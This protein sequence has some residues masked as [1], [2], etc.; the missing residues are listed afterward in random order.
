ME[1]AAAGR[2]KRV[3]N[4]GGRN[5][6][7]MRPPCPAYFFFLGPLGLEVAF[8]SNP[9]RKWVVSNF[10]KKTNNPNP[11]PIG[12]RFGLYGR[13]AGGGTRTPTMSP[14]ADFESATSTNSITPANT[15]SIIHDTPRFRKRKFYFSGKNLNRAPLRSS[16]SPERAAPD[17]ISCA[18]RG[19]LF[20]GSGVW[21]PASGPALLESQALGDHGL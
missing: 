8:R 17:R 16:G 7:T 6:H 18:V 12:K 9:F 19:G 11:S 4:Q 5:R 2:T 20:G 1:K 21:S 10:S 13:G 15:G 14:P 3:N